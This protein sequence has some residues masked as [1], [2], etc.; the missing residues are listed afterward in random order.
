LSSRHIPCRMLGPALLT[1]LLLSAC[2]TLGSRAPDTYDLTAPTDI[3]T[4]KPG[5][6]Q[7]VVSLPTALQALDSER[8]LLRPRGAQVTYIAGAQWADRLPQLLQARL[9]QT[10]ENAHRIGTVGRPE[11]KLV[12][13][14]NLA[15]EIRNFE[16]DLSNGTNAVV[17]V[18]ARM[19]SEQ[20]GKIVAANIFTA[21]IPA[22]GTDGA[23]ASAALDQAM[24]R[25]LA[26]IV[27][28]TATKI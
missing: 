24:Q 8:I 12:A 17:S 6:A 4:L 19:V 9:I 22:G 3:K 10:F 5:R 14:V 1:V 21:S 28:W 18:S 23:H 2:G 20:G 11:D 26:D 7:I 13:D 16:I 15:I 27:V 25:V